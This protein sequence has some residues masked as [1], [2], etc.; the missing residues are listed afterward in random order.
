LLLGAVRE[1]LDLQMRG[2]M[3][4]LSLQRYRLLKKTTMSIFILLTKA[5]EKKKSQIN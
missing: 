2:V 3:R 1:E 5:S 4:M